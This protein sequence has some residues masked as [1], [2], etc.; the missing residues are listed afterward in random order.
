MNRA[1]RWVPIC[2]AQTAATRMDLTWLSNET[3]TDPELECA[4]MDDMGLFRTT[5]GA[6]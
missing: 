3:V 2:A 5:K 4:T 6:M 1:A